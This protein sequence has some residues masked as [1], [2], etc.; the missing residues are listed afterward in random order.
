MLPGGWVALSMGDGVPLVEKNG[1]GISVCNVCEDDCRVTTSDSTFVVVGDAAAQVALAQF[2]RL[3][4]FGKLE[5]DPVTIDG[6]PHAWQSRRHAE[7]HSQF[8]LT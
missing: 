8:F 1:T 5:M 6:D 2:D 4:V 7:Q 3:G